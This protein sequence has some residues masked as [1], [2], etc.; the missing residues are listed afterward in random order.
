M[1]EPTTTNSKEVESASSSERRRLDRKVHPSAVDWWLAVLLGFPV[2]AAVVLAGYLI[3]I[4]RPGDASVM[5]LTGAGILGITAIFTVP[6]RYTLLT[7][8]LSIRC[9]VICY[10]VPYNT[11]REV[12]MSSTLRS[13][14]ALSLRRVVIQTDRREHILSPV[15]RE[16]FIKQ[17]NQRISA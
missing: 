1:S 2:V 14:P 10:Q 15:D 7:D 9:G 16:R 12:R 8:T 11:I 6:C 13:G 3:A 5:F 17:L 4:G